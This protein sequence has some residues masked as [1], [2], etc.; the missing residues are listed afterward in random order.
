MSD[1]PTPKYVK[2]PF[3][4]KYGGGL[5]LPG[6][7]V[8]QDIVAHLAADVLTDEPPAVPEE[9][10]ADTPS[11]ATGG[12]GASGGTGD[13]SPTESGDEPSEFEGE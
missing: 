12:T 6:D 7:L 13:A 1:A 10:Q 5:L 3:E 11:G 2:A 9:P 4:I 8:P